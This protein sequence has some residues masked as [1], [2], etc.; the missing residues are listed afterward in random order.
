[1]PMYRASFVRLDRQ[2]PGYRVLDDQ[3]DSVA[4]VAPAVRKGNQLLRDRLSGELRAMTREGVM[5]ELYD[6]YLR[7]QLPDDMDPHL[8]LMDAGAG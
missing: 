7:G 5:L 2:H 6:R 4:P 8:L 3:L 1:M